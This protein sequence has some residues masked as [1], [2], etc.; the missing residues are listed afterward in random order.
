[1]SCLRL[2]MAGTE[3]AKR[4]L[5]LSKFSPKYSQ[6]HADKNMSLATSRAEIEREKRQAKYEGKSESGK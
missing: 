2:E 3:S 5:K 1:M 6:S 4:T